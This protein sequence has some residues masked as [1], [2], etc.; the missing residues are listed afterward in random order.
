[1]NCVYDL[2]RI[3]SHE[4][5]R[6]KSAK[7][8]FAKIFPDKRVFFFVLPVIVTIVAVAIVSIFY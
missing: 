1:M 3:N 8:V 5:N 7:T 2:T 6:N 4:Q